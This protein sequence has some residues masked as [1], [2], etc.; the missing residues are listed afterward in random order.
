MLRLQGDCVEIDDFDACYVIGAV[1]DMAWDFYLVALMM[2]LNSETNVQVAIAFNEG[3]EDEIVEML[4][5][6][7][8]YD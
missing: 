5:S 3:D 7:Y 4:N 8:A 6:F 1:Y 2:A